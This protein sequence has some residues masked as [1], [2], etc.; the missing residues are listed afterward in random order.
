MVFSP[1]KLVHLEPRRGF[2]GKKHHPYVHRKAFNSAKPVEDKRPPKPVFPFP[3]YA[4]TSWFPKHRVIYRPEPD[5][6]SLEGRDPEGSVDDE[7]EPRGLTFEA[8]PESDEGS[9]DLEFCSSFSLDGADWANPHQIKC[10]PPPP[11]WEERERR[12][13]DK[14]WKDL[15]KELQ[16]KGIEEL[17]ELADK[18]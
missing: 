7:E 11:Y 14:S 4:P 9:E 2:P 12:D 3:E 6:R 1:K 10:R 18:W 15:G 5:V 16:D 17:Q 13:P 8:A